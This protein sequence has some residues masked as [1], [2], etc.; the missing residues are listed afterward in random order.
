[1]PKTRR[2]IMRRLVTTYITIFVIIVVG[3]E[4]MAYFIISSI[5]EQAARLNREQLCEQMAAQTSDF[6]DAMA[7][8]AEQ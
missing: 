3:I 5:S 2:G 8:M 1:M 6:L 7:R 4:I